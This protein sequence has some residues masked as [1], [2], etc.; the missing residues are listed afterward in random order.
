MLLR[1]ARTRLLG[2]LWKLETARA[3]RVRM[4]PS[5][6]AVRS[7][8]EVETCAAEDRLVPAKSTA[9]ISGTGWNPSGLEGQGFRAI[10]SV[11]K[12]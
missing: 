6:T 11:I 10:S 1:E 8:V 9:S 5:R 7:C 3:E 12:L 4:M 2:R